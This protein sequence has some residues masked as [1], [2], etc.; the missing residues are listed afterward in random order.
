MVDLTY[1]W[2]HKKKSSMKEAGKKK[3]FGLHKR[4]RNINE[5]LNLLSLSVI[6]LTPTQQTM[7]HNPNTPVAALCLRLGIWGREM[8]GTSD[9]S[10]R[11]T[12]ITC[13]EKGEDRERHVCHCFT[14]RPLRH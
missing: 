4:R 13:Q 12:E 14:P 10:E 7:L 1:V 3:V 11:F 6:K 9:G 2:T 5:V 8:V